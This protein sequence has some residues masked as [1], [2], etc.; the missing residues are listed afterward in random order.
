MCWPNHSLVDNQAGL[1][2]MCVLLNAVLMQS[3][4]QASAFAMY[5]NGS[6]HNMPVLCGPAPPNT[7]AAPPPHTCG[8][9]CPPS[10]S[11]RGAA[12]GAQLGPAAPGCFHCKSGGRA[13]QL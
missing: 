9:T 10:A 11:G 4:T 7:P 13:Q 2:V 3:L 12:P 5:I 1:V 8:R 6:R